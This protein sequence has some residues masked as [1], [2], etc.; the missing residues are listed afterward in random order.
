MF[1]LECF[2]LTNLAVDVYES[3]INCTIPTCTYKIN[4]VSETNILVEWVNPSDDVINATDDRINSN[5]L[6]M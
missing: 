1:L 5:K 2:L 6:T 3:E 4:C